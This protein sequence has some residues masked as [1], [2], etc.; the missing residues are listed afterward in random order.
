MWR[1]SSFCPIEKKEGIK[2]VLFF[3]ALVIDSSVGN[4]LS[5]YGMLTHNWANY[6][7]SMFLLTSD[8]LPLSCGNS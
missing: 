6:I 1:H 7:V 5:F 3:G 8:F 4:S 2:L